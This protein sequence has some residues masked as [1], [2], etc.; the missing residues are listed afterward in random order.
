MND[1]WDGNVHYY[2]FTETDRRLLNM[3]A[4]PA[5][6]AYIYEDPEAATPPVHV[7]MVASAP[8]IKTATSAP[9]SKG[10]VRS[11]WNSSRSTAP[12]KRAGQTRST[13]HTATT[14][15]F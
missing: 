15:N 13:T 7:L 2:E 1:R 11:F 8:S 10:L 6:E 4:W 3:D 9:R 12:K 5:A 14:D